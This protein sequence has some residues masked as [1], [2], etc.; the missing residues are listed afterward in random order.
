MVVMLLETRTGVSAENAPP[1][2]S[3]FDLKPTVWDP[4]N[5]ITGAYFVLDT[6]PASHLQSSLLV[7]NTGTVRGTVVL[8]PVDAFTAPTGG[9]AYR[10]RK[11]AR[12]EVG[13]WIKLSQEKITLGPGQSANIPFE[14]SIPAHVRAGD[15]VGGI[16]A[17]DLALR[18]VVPSNMPVH[19]RELRAVA[20]QLNLPGPAI[21]KLEATGIQPDG[22]TTYQRI[23]IGLRNTGNKMVKANGTL[24]ILDDKGQIVQKQEVR[25][26]TFLPQTAI[27]TRLNIRHKALPIGHYKALLNLHYGHKQILD[28]TTAFT[29]KPKKTFTG[30]V[31]SL[32]KL[33]DSED[34]LTLFA[35]WQLALGGAIGLLLAGGVGYWLVKSCMRLARQLPRRQ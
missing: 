27:L 13:T 26:G 20:V 11:D 23:Q 14:I 7:T 1:H 35:P 28:Y 10:D 18:P 21:E 24:R 32:V 9:T 30:A 31:E 25:Y 33:G 8:Y 29:I 34:L 22:G 16:V 15:H 6:H 17:E 4:H 19:I 3:G 2:L 5:P 12:K